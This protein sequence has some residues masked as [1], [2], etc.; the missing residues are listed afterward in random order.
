MAMQMQPSG[1]SLKHRR[2]PVLQILADPRLPN[3]GTGV[4]K[5]HT[6]PSPWPSGYGRGPPWPRGSYGDGRS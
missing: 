1:H 5:A 2:M 6:K 3:G 4:Q